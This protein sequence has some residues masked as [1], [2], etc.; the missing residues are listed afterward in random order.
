[1]VYYTTAWVQILFDDTAPLDE[2]KL[3]QLGH[4]VGVLTEWDYSAIA[5]ACV[6]QCGFTM[7]ALF[8]HVPLED[9]LHLLA[10]GLDI[11]ELDIE[12]MFTCIQS[13]IRVRPSESDC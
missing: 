1:M 7:V 5:I 2:A 3:V 13:C 6:D 11:G 12:M 9:G 4:I 8:F 10:G